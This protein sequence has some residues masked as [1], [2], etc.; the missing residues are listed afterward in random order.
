MSQRE[1][2]NEARKAMQEAGRKY[3]ADS[4]ERSKAAQ[5]FY[6]EDSKL[7]AERRKPKAYGAR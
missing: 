5:R 4:P 7:R 1:R 6:D 3:G 2:V